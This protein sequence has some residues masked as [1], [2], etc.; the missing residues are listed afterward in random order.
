MHGRRSPDSRSARHALGELYAW[1][2]A[3]ADDLYPNNRD[4]DA[5]PASTQ[6]AIRREHAGLVDCLVD[7]FESGPT[8]RR[9]RATAGHLVTYWTWRSLVVEEGL[10]N[11]EAIELAVDIIGAAATSH[12]T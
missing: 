4:I 1:Y 2:E 11:E 5:M 9:L 8:A 3:N 12:P 7:G 6:E 10:S